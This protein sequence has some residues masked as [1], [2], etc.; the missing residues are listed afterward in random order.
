ML[1]LVRDGLLL[2]LPILPYGVL[3]ML[4]RPGVGFDL[5]VFWE[6]ARAVGHGSSPYDP[7]AVAHMRL[8]EQHDPRLHPIVAFSVYLPALFTILVPLAWLP[9]TV[10]AVLGIAALALAAGVALWVMG[11]RDWRCYAVAF[12]SFPICTSIMLG[13]IST[14]PD[15]WACAGLARPEHRRRRRCDDRREVVPLA[16]RNRDRGDPRS[17]TRRGLA[18][19]RR[20]VDTWFVDDYRIRR[21]RALSRDPLRPID[22]RSTHELLGDRARLRHRCTARP[23]DVAGLALGLA[24]AAFAYRAGLRGNRDSAFTLALVAALLMSPIV[25][26]HYLTLMFLPIAARFPRF[27]RIWLVPLLLWAYPLQAAYGTTWA[28]IGFWACVTTIVIATTRSTHTAAAASR[29]GTLI[30]N[31]SRSGRIELHPSP[32]EIDDGASLGLRQRARS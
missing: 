9:W 12:G 32:V 10:A 2:S 23:R 18:R 30:R 22:D 29:A 28:L 13:T 19:R 8:V 31:L 6:A 26:M 1:P 20:G 16:P 25:W 17:P 4:A 7:A 15:A 21:R 3:I 11:V 27:N 14:V 5:H 24:L